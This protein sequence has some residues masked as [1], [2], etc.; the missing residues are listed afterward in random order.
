MRLTSRW[1]TGMPA[2]AGTEMA[3]LTHGMT[4]TGMPAARQAMTS[5]PPRP[6]TNGSPPFSRTTVRPSLALATSIRSISACGTAWWPGVLPTS[7]SSAPGHQSA[8]R[9]VGPRRSW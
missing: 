4:V 5:S 2:A 7:T 8:S 3:L 6:K 1:V 9:S